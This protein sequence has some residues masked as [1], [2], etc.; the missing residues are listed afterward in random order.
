MKKTT[1]PGPP[2]K[3]GGRKT[4]PPAPLQRGEKTMPQSVM[5]KRRFQYVLTGVKFDFFAG[6]TWHVD[7][8]SQGNPEKKIIPDWMYDYLK[9]FNIIK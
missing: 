6:D 7:P 2:L 8:Q 1:P 9:E 4:S 5:V 3:K